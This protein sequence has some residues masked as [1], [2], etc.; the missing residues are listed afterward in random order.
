MSSSVRRNT[1]VAVITWVSI[2]LPWGN[3]L[4][5]D[6]KLLEFQHMPKTFGQ[7]PGDQSGKIR[8]KQCQYS[9]NLLKVLTW[10]IAGRAYPHNLSVKTLV[11]FSGKSITRKHEL[12]HCTVLQMKEDGTKT[13]NSIQ[14]AVYDLWTWKDHS[15][16]L[17]YSDDLFCVTCLR[18]Q[19][20]CHLVVIVKH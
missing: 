6:G 12:K 11:I 13:N 5:T 2:W 17:G 1:F 19:L 20:A 16:Q 3:I 8:A 14:T 15:L 9:L 10:E 4:L 18:Q 7:T